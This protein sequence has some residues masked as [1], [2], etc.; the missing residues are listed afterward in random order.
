MALIPAKIIARLRGTHTSDVAE[1]SWVWAMRTNGEVIC[2]MTAVNGHRERNPWQL[3]TQVPAA[4]RPIVQRNH[5]YA[6]A[7]LAQIA[8]QCGHQVAEL[9]D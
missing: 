3:V 2:R 5:T 4:Q 1:L 9:S 8:R 6:R 7:V